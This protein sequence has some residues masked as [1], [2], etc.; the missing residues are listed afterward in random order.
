MKFPGNFVGDFLDVSS[1]LEIGGLSRSLGSIYTGPEIFGFKH[2]GITE[3]AE[4]LTYRGAGSAS[5]R[6]DTVFRIH[7][8]EVK[9]LCFDPE[10]LPGGQSGSFVTKG[11]PT[12]SQFGPLKYKGETPALVE[13]I[14]GVGS[15]LEKSKGPT[16]GGPRQFSGAV[17]NLGRS[18][19]LAS[20]RI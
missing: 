1:G 2:L 8:A 18:R 17:I 19:V 11:S 5:R 13:R 9:G 10:S 20:S 4:K 15:N 12:G 14:A 7:T 16:P 6:R 3:L